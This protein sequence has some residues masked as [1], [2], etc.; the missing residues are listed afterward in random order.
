[1]TPPAGAGRLSETGF[2]LDGRR[3]EPALNRLSGAPGP[4]QLEP[5]VMAVLVCLAEAGGA[6]VAGDE[7][8]D[9]VWS[10]PSVGD[11]V[12]A[13]AVAEL[14]RAFG[15]D[16]ATAPRV[17]ETIP[18]GGYRLVAPVAPLAAGASPVGARPALFLVP[19]LVASLAVVGGALV[20]RS[21]LE[22]AVANRRPLRFV[23]IS[24][25]EDAQD[26]AVSPDGTRVAWARATRDG[27]SDIVVRL[28]G[29]GPPITLTA[30]P[31]EDRHPA[32]SPDGTWLAFARLAP[33]GCALFVVP[34]LGGAE[35]RLGPCPDREH[36]AL[37]WSP[38]GR[39]LAHTRQDA[40]GRR[41]IA[42]LGVDDG[43]V[44]RLTTPPP[45]HLGDEWPAFSPDGRL[46]AFVR[47]ATG[48]VGDLHRVGIDG[49][50]PVRLTRDHAD[51]IGVTWI[52]R[53]RGLVFSSNRAGLYS[54]WSA[55][56]SGGAPKLLASGGA[57]LEQP[58][59]SRDGL[60][61]AYEDWDD[62]IR[63]WRVPL[64]GEGAAAPIAAGPDERNYEPALSPDGTRLAW[65]STR[66]GSWELWEAA[67][68]GS[69]ARRL[70]DLGG[71]LVGQPRWSPD[72]S[73]I[74]VV[75]RPEGQ[76]DLYLA[77]VEG[78]GWRRLT[79]DP[80]DDVAPAWSRDGAS[81]LFASRRGGRWGLWRA[82]LEGG[83]P[84]RVLGDDAYAAAESPDGEWLYYTRSGRS[85][86]WRR[87]R[88]GG[89]EQPVLSELLPER[90][91]DWVLN[92]AGLFYAADIAGQAWLLRAEP[93]GAEP[94][95]LVA[96]ERPGWPG[97]EVSSDGR[98]LYVSRSFRR[99]SRIAAL[100]RA[101]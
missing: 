68:D 39:W 26:P 67:A 54:L 69:G 12:L 64:G 83:E 34:A 4:R 17:V 97:L 3:V 30:S 82:P 84:V 14:R 76:A 31:D 56:A 22:D 96:L 38:D 19:L 44:R 29:G 50:E 46:L 9:R 53:G 61:V 77:E 85:G 70:S 23:P 33:D 27:G 18:G 98:W 42:L 86:L 37:S 55:S 1:M 28:L 58:S 95:P 15:D 40:E 51:I 99:S 59:A 80:A 2:T 78:G 90:A 92:Q 72:G 89:A 101:P 5:R 87:P 16:D 74:A 13:R 21:V 10:D 48:G 93:D 88:G 91:R 25:D 63:L 60:L 35:R 47:S 81:L 79:R 71:P 57:R 24:G 43:A 7:L 36:L 100:S 94:R 49:G 62:E 32:W 6:V 66:S 65:G 11:D 73:R 52:G 45:G 41:G 75:A 8:R 20:A